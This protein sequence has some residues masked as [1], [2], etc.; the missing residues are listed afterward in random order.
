M[1]NGDCM[2]TTNDISTELNR[3][4]PLLGRLKSEVVHPQAPVGYL[5]DHLPGA[6]W[7]KI[8]R[9]KT[10]N[11][12]PRI[13]QMVLGLSAAAAILLAVTL[14]VRFTVDPAGVSP[15]NTLYASNGIT[16]EDIIY[17]LMD[18]VRELDEMDIATG[19]DII[20]EKPILPEVDIPAVHAWLE[21]YIDVLDEDL[22]ADEYL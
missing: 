13:V 16:Q 19:L 7:Q 6:V 12:K 10:Y 18:N 15:A 4:S 11:N 5:E 14:T 2:K 22:I 9:S 8:D 17:Y 1:P 3:I 21:E 20:A